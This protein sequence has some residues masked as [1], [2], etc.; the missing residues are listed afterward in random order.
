ME[1]TVSSRHAANMSEYRRIL[2]KAA[3]ICSSSERCSNDIR[4]KMLSWGLEPVEADNAVRF[5][6]ENKFID[7]SRF[8]TYFVRDKLKINKWGRIKIRFALR[9]KKVDE[10]I[11][12]E[13][14]AQINETLYNEILDELLQSKI[15]S[16]GSIK[17]AANKAKL[18]RFA[19]QRGFTSSEI[20]TSIDRINLQ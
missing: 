19:A 15:K 16:I 6:I 2:D 7:D 11:I 9:Q 8:A 13:C 10:G 14:L 3:R 4:E 5:L 1:R 20:F 12:E 18:L 17:V